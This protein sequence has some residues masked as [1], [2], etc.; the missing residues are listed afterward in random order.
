MN[1]EHAEELRELAKKG[2]IKMSLRGIGKYETT[3]V[4][5]KNVPNKISKDFIE[6]EQ[7]V[8]I[9]IDRDEDKPAKCYLYKSSCPMP[10]S[11]IQ[12]DDIQEELKQE[13]DDLKDCTILVLKKENGS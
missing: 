6:K 1:K 10:S 12:T 9:F 13:D 4:V 11:Y 7:D 8:S 3:V 2:L 5:H